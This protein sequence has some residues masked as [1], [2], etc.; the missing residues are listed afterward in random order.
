MAISVVVAV[1]PVADDLIARIAERT[2]ALKVGAGTRGPDLG[3]VITDEQRQRIVGYVDG[4]EREGAKVVNDGRVVDPDGEAQGFWVGP[5]V[6]DN[7]TSEMAVYRDEVF[8]PVL[9][10][11]RVGTFDEGLELVNANDYGNGAALFT[12]S[13]TAARRFEV[14]VTAGMVG[15]NVPIPVPAAHF[16]FGGWKSSLFGDLHA[17][18]PDGVRF[19]TRGKVVTSRW[20]EPT[21]GVDLAFPRG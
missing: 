13:G 7:V 12:R 1:E 20:P 19:F 2:R 14:E 17:Y 6:L 3:P 18:G 9:S 16:S 15:I 11:V 21:P 10:V 4:A 5:T 8:G